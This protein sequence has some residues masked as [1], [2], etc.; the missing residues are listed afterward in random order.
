MAKIIKTAMGNKIDVEH[1]I[2]KN[3]QTIAVG[4]R[5][6]NARGDLLGPGGKVVKTRDQ[7][8]KEYY[9]ANTPATAADPN[10]PTK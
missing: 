4:N 3:E 6:V 1:L 8:M 10:K 5:K 7:I 2:A 9:E